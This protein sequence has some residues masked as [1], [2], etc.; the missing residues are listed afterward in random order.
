[1][2]PTSSPAARLA[3]AALSLLLASAPRGAAAGAEGG[4]AAAAP[5][6]LMTVDDLSRLREVEEPRISPDGAWV[7]YVVAVHDLERDKRLGHLWMTSWDGATT[8]QLTTGTKE[9][10]SHPRWSPD[11]RYLAFLSSRGD[12]SEAEQVWLLPRAGGEPRRLT[13]APAGVEDF[14]WSPDGTRLV[15]AM[16]DADAAPAGAEAGK[17]KVP[18]PIVIDRYYFKEDGAGYLTR[19]RRH[20]HLVE[21]ATG[22]VTQLTRGES[23]DLNP[24]W[25]PD[26]KS[27]AFLSQR[28]ADADRSLGWEVVVVE[29]RAGAEPRP[30]TRFEGA[31]NNPGGEGGTNRIAWSPDGRQIAFLQ[32]GTPKLL[33]YAP[34]RLAV[35]PAAGGP[36][37]VLTAG[38]DRWVTNPAWAPDGRSVYAIVEEDRAQHLVRVPAAGGR[39][40]PVLD[41]RRAVAAYDVGRSGRIAALF[42]TATTLNEVHVLDGGAWR[43]LSRQ[44]DAL[45][46]GLQLGAME[47]TSF[48]SRDGTVISGF[49][50]KP[51]GFKEGTRYPAIVRI[52][53]G[54]VG[55]FTWGLDLPYDPCWQLLAARGYLVI[56]ANPRGS[57][58]KG[59][60]FAA[61]ALAD[62]GNKDAQDVLA[63]V[64]D[65]VARGLADPE[66]LG[67]GG[68]SYG[69]IL[70]NAIIAQDQRFKAATSGAGMSNMLG[71]YGSDMYVRE[72]EAE[73]GTPW[74]AT[75]TWLRLSSP[76]LHADRIRTPTLFLVG[77]KDFNVPVIGSEQM[78][79][80]LRSLGRDTRL[81]IYPGESHG[82]TRPSY[83]R[84]RAQRYLDWYD[85]HLK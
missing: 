21:V 68:W 13:E 78:Y 44:N 66:R 27:I 34:T 83:V 48:K 8:V 10:E 36:V 35:V 14:A 9:P 54:P 79:Q 55:Q 69:A 46:A 42:A 33:Y 40:E 85:A 7:A 1:M 31:V 72:W 63:A 2:L 57:L 56:L 28:G 15:L 32:G 41:G 71:G 76:F 43:P 25:S 67:L 47:E 24:E 3:L 4:P 77:E 45:L 65:A 17:E 50:V 81:V 5:K 52:H 59:Q 38:V 51:P 73:L 74:S 23:E 80:A 12:E 11:G 16:K 39:P 60:A 20:L 58:G 61:A 26:G 37:R 29:A 70:T 19:A 18:P 53:G 75:E 82:F 84:D 64:D 49:V 62:W 22:K 6:R 30:L